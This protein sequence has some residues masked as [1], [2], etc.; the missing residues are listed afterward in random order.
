MWPTLQQP[1]ALSEGAQ[2]LLQELASPPN[3][4][5]VEEPITPE[6][7]QAQWRAMKEMTSSS[8]SGLHIGL[9]KANAEHDIMN[10]IDTKFRR[11]CYQRGISL[12]RWFKG[13]DVELLKD[14]GNFDVNCLRTIVLVEADYN[15]NCKL[16]G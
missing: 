7:N 1:T 5:P 14:P 12:C 15:M 16:L 8:P 4:I 13:I 2:L 6:V 10:K 9:W 3:M 11:I